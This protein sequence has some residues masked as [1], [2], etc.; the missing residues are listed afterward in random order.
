MAG[1]D[2][3]LELHGYVKA[4]TEY[5]IGSENVQA[6]FRDDIEPAIHDDGLLSQDRR[7]QSNDPFAAS[8]ASSVPDAVVRNRTS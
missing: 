2:G 6:V 4:A 3:A 1:V 5:L 7:D 8:R